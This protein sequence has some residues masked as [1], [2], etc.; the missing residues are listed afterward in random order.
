MWYVRHSLLLC[1]YRDNAEGKKRGGGKI[2]R[3][4]ERNLQLLYK[5]DDAWIEDIFEDFYEY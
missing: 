2:N 5:D 4:L 3:G 1:Y